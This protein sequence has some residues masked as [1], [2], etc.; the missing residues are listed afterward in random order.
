MSGTSDEGKNEK[1]Q[2]WKANNLS[3]PAANELSGFM[4]ELEL[5]RSRRDP[6]LMEEDGHDGQSTPPTLPS[7]ASR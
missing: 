1:D 4:V 2:V 7:F 3:G 6:I 5:T